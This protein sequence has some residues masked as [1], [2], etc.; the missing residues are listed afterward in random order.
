MGEVHPRNALH[1]LN[2]LRVS[3]DHTVARTGLARNLKERC[4]PG[5]L[6]GKADLSAFQTA[7][8]A[9]SA[10]DRNSCGSFVIF[11]P[12]LLHV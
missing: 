4:R 2:M 1:A 9:S 7:I 10:P 12:S 5:K 11:V 8:P 6:S 3:G